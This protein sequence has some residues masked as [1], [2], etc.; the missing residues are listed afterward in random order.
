MKLS[1]Q[2]LTKNYMTKT[3]VEDFSYTFENGIYGL[4]GPNGSGKSTLMRMLCDILRPSHGTI[5][6]DGENIHRMDERYRDLLGYL[7]QNF[8]YYPQFTVNDFLMYFATLKGYE[9]KEAKTRVQEVLEMVNLIEE[10]KHKINHLSGG[11][12]QRLGIAQA[13]LNDPRILIIDEPTVG[14]DPKERS[15]FKSILARCAKDKIVILSTHIVSDIESLATRIL[16]MREGKLYLHGSREELIQ[17]LESKVYSFP[18]RE[19]E[20]EEYQT[21]VLVISILPFHD[22]VIVRCISD[23]P[24]REDATKE[25][26]ILEDLY[27]SIFRDDV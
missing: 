26:P 4:L 20:L 14:L 8:G 10:R 17:S 25:I 9:K 15:K 16:I 13:L 19:E 21:T 24:P 11:M 1:A 2:N 27:L 6:L 3:A 5:T 23:T 18:C 12:K 22:H 7:P